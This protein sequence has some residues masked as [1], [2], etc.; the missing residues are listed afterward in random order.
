MIPYWKT[1]CAFF[2]GLH[3]QILTPSHPDGRMVGVDFGDPIR[4]CAGRGQICR[5]DDL[6]GWRPEAVG[7]LWADESG[8]LLLSIWECFWESEDEQPAEAVRENGKIIV[9][10][11]ARVFK[12]K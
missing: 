1:L 2:L 12:P 9:Q 6:T 10:T 11:P 4:N 3:A 7:E 5:I 8:A